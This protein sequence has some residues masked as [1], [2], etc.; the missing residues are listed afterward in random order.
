MPAPLEQAIVRIDRVAQACS[1][2]FW[3]SG[4]VVDRD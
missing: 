3:G 1:Q 4:T 2:A